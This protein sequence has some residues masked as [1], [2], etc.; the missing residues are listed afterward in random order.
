M[1]IAVL[2]FS[3]SQIDIIDN[4]PITKDVDKNGRDV[5]EQVEFI[6]SE[7]LGYNLDEISWME[8]GSDT[9]VNNYDYSE[10]C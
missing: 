3:N 6:L 8:Y 5:T 1:K 10:M 2:D 9:M 7:E 4:I